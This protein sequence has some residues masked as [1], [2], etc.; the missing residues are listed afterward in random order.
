LDD[1]LVLTATEAAGN[2]MVICLTQLFVALGLVFHPGKS[3]LKPLTIIKHLGFNLNIPK[4]L[5]ELTDTQINKITAA[6]TNL[7]AI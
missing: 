6:S 2:N 1:L 4:R 7:L 5:F 3:Q